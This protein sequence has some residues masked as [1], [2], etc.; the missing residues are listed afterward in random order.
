LCPALVRPERGQ[1]VLHHGDSASIAFA[2]GFDCIL[3]SPPFFH[4]TAVSRAHGESPRIRDLDAFASWTAAVLN[5]AY[6]IQRSGVPLCFV[7]TDIKYRRQLLPVGY[8]I[9]DACERAGL[10]VRA[11]WIWERLAS[12]SPYAPSISNI[13]VLGDVAPSLLRCPGIFRSCDAR[14]RN[15]PTSFT[16]DLFSLLIQQL[17]PTAASI[18]DPFAGAGSVALAGHRVKRWTVGVEISDSAIAKAQLLLKEVPNVLF[19]DSA[20][21]RAHQ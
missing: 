4:P 6:G 18:L 15:T 1:H 21:P 10:P 9:A 14:R 12:F 3:T 19:K 13:F 20:I 2:S 11:H 17:T 16:P 5:R 8:R 7:K